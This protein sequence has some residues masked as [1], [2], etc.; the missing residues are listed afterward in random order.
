[1]PI[2]TTIPANA[3][4]RNVIKSAPR[5]AEYQSA[6]AMDAAMPAVVKRRTFRLVSR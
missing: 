5:D 3:P 4:S 1:M 2:A 6:T